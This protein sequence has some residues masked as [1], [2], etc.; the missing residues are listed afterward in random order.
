[1]VEPTRSQHGLE[2]LKG[3]GK[4]LVSRLPVFGELIAG[5]DAYKRSQLER[6]VQNLLGYLQKRVD[7]VEELF[8][9]EWIT[10]DEGQQFARKVVDCA[11]NAELE[12]KHQL[13]AN[14]LINGIQDRQLS[15]LEKL[16]FVDMLRHLSL[17]SLCVLA[18]MHKLYGRH[19]IYAD[20]PKTNQ[21]AP[22]ISPQGLIPQLSPKLHPY[23]IESALGEMQA[24]GLFS[25][26]T[27]WRLGGDG[28]FR[29]DSSIENPKIYGEFAGKFVAFIS[30]KT[31]HQE[32]GGQN[33]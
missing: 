28:Q 26:F 13:F 22:Q 33:G 21:A 29:D 20:K 2:A 14:A 31:S 9:E 5:W 8:S 15:T 25:R 1:M 11:V 10:S 18:E 16:K 19:I 3:A 6:Y 17:A 12:D 24:V 4:A 30:D 27:A 7:N 23:V 32:L